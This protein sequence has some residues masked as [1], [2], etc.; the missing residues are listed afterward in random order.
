MQ[1]YEIWQWVELKIKVFFISKSIKHVLLS[2]LGTVHTIL[3]LNR[4][5]NVKIRV[6]KWVDYT[7]ISSPF[8]KT[9]KRKSGNYLPAPSQS[10]PLILVMKSGVGLPPWKKMGYPVFLSK[11][12][13]QKTRSLIDKKRRGSLVSSLFE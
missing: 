6:E 9:A 4:V 8:K 12:R 11:S 5:K 3:F 7:S 2:K 1:F 10:V 13:L